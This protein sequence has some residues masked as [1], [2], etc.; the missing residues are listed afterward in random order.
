MRIDGISP[1][2]GRVFD[3][4]RG[5]ADAA[6]QAL[7]GVDT[8]IVDCLRDGPAHPTHAHLEKTLGWIERAG[9]RHAVLTHMNHQADYDTLAAACPDGVVPAYDGMVLDVP[10]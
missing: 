3:R 10:H 9:V 4:R 1:R 8:W 7:E 5:A 6:F 2:A